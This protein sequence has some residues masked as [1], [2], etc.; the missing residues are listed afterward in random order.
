MIPITT[1]TT[2]PTPNPRRIS[3]VLPLPTNSPPL[4]SLPPIGLIKKGQIGPLYT[5]KPAPIRYSKLGK[6]TKDQGAHPRHRL[7][8]QALALDLSTNLHG[9]TSPGGILYTGGRDGLICSWELGLPTKRRKK[10]YGKSNDLNGDKDEL[11]SDEYSD[12]SDIESKRI[13]NNRWKRE[14]LDPLDLGDLKLPGSGLGSG[15]KF[16][17]FNKSRR[18]S[19]THTTRGLERE[20]P[21]LDS[22]AVEDRYEVDDTRIKTLPVPTARFRQCVQ[23]HTDWVNDIV[24]CD[25]NRTRK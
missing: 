2:V 24:L 6:F 25:Y 13:S 23:S 19:S 8:V 7:A 10:S 16:K 9:E 20:E 14:D 21:F 4:L 22:I 12:N 3:Y 11:S 1:T 15:K 5:S 18:D 17:E